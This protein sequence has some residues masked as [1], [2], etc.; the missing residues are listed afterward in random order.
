M[1]HVA[2]RLTLL[3]RDQDGRTSATIAMRVCAPARRC[4]LPRRKDRDDVVFFNQRIGM[5]AISGI[6]MFGGRAK[7]EKRNW[8]KTYFTWIESVLASHEPYL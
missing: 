1:E 8:T 5:V 3:G 4:R 2:H 7:L 6:M